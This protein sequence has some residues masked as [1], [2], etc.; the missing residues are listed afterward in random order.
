MAGGSRYNPGGLKKLKRLAVICI[1]L[2]FVCL[3]CSSYPKYY[4]YSFNGE[5]SEKINRVALAPLNLF[6]PMPSPARGKEAMIY[7]AV[8]RYLGDHG[9]TCLTGE[10]V[11]GVWVEENKRIGG[12]YNPADGSVA[13]EKVGPC[14][15]NT[16]VRVCGTQSVQAVIF[17]EIVARP[18]FI[19]G[20]TVYWDGAEQRIENADLT[21]DFYS[22]TTM[23][24]SLKIRILDRD[25]R[26]I[27]KNIAGIEHPFRLRRG[28]GIREWEPTKGPLSDP[29]GIE[30]A[31]AMALHPFIP[32]P[33]YPR[34]PSFSEE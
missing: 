27:L 23:A 21:A 3:G 30:R 32:Y 1:I 33:K 15:K 7:D 10:T 12:I 13:K 14:L 17:P 31:A 34:N 25:G 26:G 22:G 18:A 2:V 20:T 4:P 8:R 9:V 16:V 11:S 24:L 29:A 19:Y 5:S 28:P 6:S